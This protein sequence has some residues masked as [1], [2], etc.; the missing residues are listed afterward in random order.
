VG[1]QA[2]SDIPG[3]EL[4]RAAAF[5]AAL[6]RFL[7]RTDEVSAGASLTSQRYDLLLAVKTADG[8]TST[9]GELA[10]RLSLRQ[11]AATELVKRAEEAGLI[12]RSVSVTDRRVSVLRLTETGERRL[13]QAFAALHQERRELAEA[14]RAVEESY[15][16]YSHVTT[17]LP[18]HGRASARQG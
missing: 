7:A 8:E 12:Q 5:R 17:S 14:M 2:P 13:M 18:G 3:E 15:R 6:R 1:E 9:V 16:S 10:R 4:E 11:P